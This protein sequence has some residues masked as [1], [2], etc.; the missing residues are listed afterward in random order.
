MQNT[1]IAVK[2]RVSVPHTS[3]PAPELD[4]FPAIAFGRPPGWYGLELAHRFALLCR[5]QAQR[6]AFFRLAIERLGHRCR[7]AH[8]AEQQDLHMEVAAVIRYP[9]H[10][11]HPDF[12]RRLGGLPVRLDPA[13]FAGPGG[14]PARF[15]ESC[16]PK[17]LVYPHGAH[18]FIFL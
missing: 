5:L 10:V 15:E 9:Q 4:N 17:P 16:G 13:Q 1:Q 2:T 8:L 12:T 6:A 18:A 7:A 3:A 14:P 11:S